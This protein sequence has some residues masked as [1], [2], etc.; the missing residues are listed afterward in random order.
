MSDRES[1]YGSAFL[2]GAIIGGAIGALAALVL[3]PKSGRELRRDIA[4]RSTELYDKA[5]EFFQR[6]ELGNELPPVAM[7]EG[8]A[9]AE[10]IIQTARDHAET[11]LS[12]AEQVLRD[13]RL[14]AVNAK[15]NVQDNINRV[16]DAARAS[17]DVFKMEMDS[18][19]HTGN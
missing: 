6:D 2:T 14:K 13:A 1:N 16:R 11:L 9:R 12:N 19:Q 17:V 15:E 8:R 5:Q 18:D 4:D 3:A 10:R 7:N